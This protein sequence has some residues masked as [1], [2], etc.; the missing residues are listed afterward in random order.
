MSMYIQNNYGTIHQI[1]GSN[2]TIQNG[3]VSEAPTAQG[4]KVH[5]REVEDL[6]YEE[7]QQQPAEPS[8]NY[9]TSF[10]NITQFRTHDDCMRLLLN[11]LSSS[12]KKSA[13]CRKLFDEEGRRWFNLYDQSSEK[14]AT[15]LAQFP[16]KVS[17]KASDIEKYKTEFRVEVERSRK[18]KYGNAED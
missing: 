15:L 1:E 11:I 3:V 6:P 4:E 17:I 2:V 8:T 18:A 7:V 13:I 5:E 9:D 14:I 10:F 12:D 16:S